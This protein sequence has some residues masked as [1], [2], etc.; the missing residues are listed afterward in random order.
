MVGERSTSRSSW[1]RFAVVIEGGLRHW[2]PEI[3]TAPFNGST[4]RCQRMTSSIGSRR[5]MSD[6][7]DALL[8]TTAIG[9]LWGEGT[10][11]HQ[12]NDAF[13]E[14]VGWDRTE[15]ESGA[16][17]WIARTPEE[18]RRVDLEGMER[19]KNGEPFPMIEKEYFRADGTR[20]P[21]LIGG[22]V[23]SRDPFKW[24]SLVLDLTDSKR[25]EREKS[26]ALHQQELAT[27]AAEQQA[28]EEHAAALAL[29]RAV[30][31][32]SLPQ[33]ED[34]R[35]T[36]RYLP[37]DLMVGGDWYDAIALPGGRLF[38]SIGDV[39][40]HGH[41]SAQL[42]GRLSN[43]ARI[44]ARLGHRP[45]EIIDILPDVLRASDPRGL[46]TC[47]CATVDSGGI[48]TLAAAGHLPPL[49]K[50]PDGTV[51]RI[52]PPLLPPISDLV[53]SGQECQ[54]ELEPGA[55][56][57]LYTDGLIERRSEA[58]DISLDRLIDTVAS[59]PGGSPEEVADAL[60]STIPTGQEDD[61]CL[62]VLQREIGTRNPEGS[63]PS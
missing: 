58:I 12:A 30:L 26:V 6:L 14:M 22:I 54:I 35:L 25:R 46:A 17:D 23:L 4:R 53:T 50:H 56:L 48:L 5:I 47:I 19:L 34:I 60:L 38:L 43:A 41:E 40:G 7:L 55:M 11:V 9:V 28:R 31:P 8:H 33:T 2:G 3:Q 62:L 16:I 39:A 24:L 42:M 29:Q 61:V 49:I 36:A 32:S 44:A 57:V 27:L 45:A 15:L 13:I 52:R 63:Q 10:A 37:A 18:Y 59:I 1:V 21:V 20:V 51:D